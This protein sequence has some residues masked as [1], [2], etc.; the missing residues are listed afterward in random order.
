MPCFL[1]GMS[2]D[3]QPK[4]G[5]SFV[6]QVPS[7]CG[8]EPHL[9]YF[10]GTQLLN[11]AA[12]RRH[13]LKPTTDYQGSVG[14]SG[15]KGVPWLYTGKN[16]KIAMRYGSHGYTDKY[17]EDDSVEF[18]DDNMTT[19][20]KKKFKVIIG[21][22]ALMPWPHHGDKVNRGSMAAN[23]YL[24]AEGTYAP[25]W[26][27]IICTEGKRI[28]RRDQPGER[29]WPNS[30]ANRVYNQKLKRS[31]E[32]MFWYDKETGNISK[33]PTVIRQPEMAEVLREGDVSILERIATT[34]MTDE[35][36]TALE[37]TR[38]RPDRDQDA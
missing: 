24:F 28:D 36:I 9:A 22:H 30:K 14:A 5:H 37:A 31:F 20:V 38:L 10:H 33:P 1:F 6:Q 7:R 21:I 12:V 26:V 13:G 8:E 23:Q 2:P 19:T 25:H 15:I 27:E 16:R 35:E 17:T 3:V 34:R 32:M 18:L 29:R 11:L 4:E